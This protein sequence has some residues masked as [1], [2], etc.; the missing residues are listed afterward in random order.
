[1]GR[2]WT[3][4]NQSMAVWLEEIC[5][6][7][8]EVE[9]GGLCLRNGRNPCECGVPG[10]E[11]LTQALSGQR[12]AQLAFLGAAFS[13][14]PFLDLSSRC[15]SARCLS[16]QYIKFSHVIHRKHKARQGAGEADITKNQKE[17][18]H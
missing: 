5:L 11:L 14:R 9:K 8:Q 18:F 2:I 6:R 4:R 10:P 12:C 1:M 16:N 13:P 15:H 17:S 3:G 7:S